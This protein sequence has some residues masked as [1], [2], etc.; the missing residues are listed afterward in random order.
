M[1]ISKLKAI[2]LYFGMYTNTKFLGKVKLMKLFYFL[3]FMHVK[4][5]GAPIT[6]DTYVKLEHGPI[7]SAIKNL[8]DSAADDIDN[9]ILVDT[10][11]FERPEGTEMIRVIPLR[12]FTEKDRKLFSP[13]ELDILN[14]VCQRFGDK[15]TKYIKD[16]SHK[17]ASFRETEFLENI[18]YTLATKD[19]DCLVSE[20]EIK[21]LL[22]I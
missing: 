11:K 20:E 14:K 13:T 19:K 18:P 7:P 1:P 16:I 22:E 5:Y 3:D 21:M 17:E 15:N 12:D 2:L 6:Y 10:I 4:Q 8:I 9:S